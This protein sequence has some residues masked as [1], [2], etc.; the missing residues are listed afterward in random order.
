M[1]GVRGELLDIGNA[2][3]DTTRYLM[4][5]TDSA[6]SLDRYEQRLAD[7]GRHT[8]AYTA[9][10]VRFVEGRDPDGIRVVITHP[11]PQKHPRSVIGSRL[12]I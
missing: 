3:L 5:A 8:H 12:Y 7:T 10:G 4:W 9:G 2:L 1:D 11:S 6:A